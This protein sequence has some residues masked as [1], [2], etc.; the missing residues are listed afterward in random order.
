MCQA[1]Q[2]RSSSRTTQIRAVTRHRRPTTQKNVREVR[3]KCEA[4]GRLRPQPRENTLAISGTHFAA[5]ACMI[6][7][8]VNAFV[9]VLGVTLFASAISKECAP[10]E[11]S[12]ED[13]D[14]KARS[15]IFRAMFGGDE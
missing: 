4:R 12:L 13:A 7:L 2:P 3:K 14:R 11:G 1:N 6:A 9:I 5:H 10:W 8:I 15:K